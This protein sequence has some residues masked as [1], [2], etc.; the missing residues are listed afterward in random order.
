M[1]ETLLILFAWLVLGALV[2][3]AVACQWLGS[4]NAVVLDPAGSVVDVALLSVAYATVLSGQALAFGRKTKRVATTVFQFLLCVKAVCV[5]VLCSDDLWPTA[6]SSGI[7]PMYSAVTLAFLASFAWT[8]KD[9]DRDRDRDAERRPDDDDDDGCEYGYETL[10]GDEEGDDERGRDHGQDDEVRHATIR[11]LLGFAAPDAL[12]LTTGFV[13][14]SLAA[15]GMALVPYLSGQVIDYASIDPDRQMFAL[16]IWRLLGVALVTGV[17]T[18]LRGGLFTFATTKLTVR[19]RTRLFNSLLFQ[20]VGIYDMSKSGDITSRLAA[21]TTTVPDNVCLNMNIMMRSITQAAMVLVFMFRT[22]WR[23][24]V[25][26][27]TLVPCTIVVTKVYGRIYQKLAKQVQSRLA[28]ANDVAVESLTGISTV[29]THAAEGSVMASYCDR[30]QEYYHT[31]FKQA[32]MYSAYMVVSTFLSAGVITVGKWLSLA[33]SLA[34]SLSHPRSLT[35]VSR[36]R[37]A[38]LWFGGS[39]VFSGRMSP[40]DL[41]SFMLYQQSLTGSFQ[42]LGDVFSSL[43]GAIGAADKVV[44]L[45]ERRPAFIETGTSK[46]DRGLEGRIELRDVTFAYP[47]RMQTKVLDG[48]SLHV[49][50]GEVVALVGP[51]GGGKSS[52]VK[53]IERQYLPQRGQILIDGRDIGEY[54]KKWLRRRIGLVGQEPT[55]FARTIRRNII[56]GLEEADGLSE[57]EVPT[58]HQIEEAAKLANA[59]DFIMS[60]PK[61]YDTYCGERGTALSGGQ[62]QRLAIARALVRR[63]AMLLLDEATSALDSNSEAMVQEALEHAMAGRSVIVIAHRLSTIQNADRICVLQKGRIVEQGTHEELLATGGVYEG[64][65][66]RQLRR[67]DSSLSR[68]VSTLDT[69]DVDRMRQ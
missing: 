54:D 25:V 67:A 62:K 24:T 10:P 5:A 38:V 39:L 44:E 61:G 60:L 42:Q 1:R 51:S 19:I 52:I 6:G 7:V 56:Y 47:A 29:K 58:K 2:A 57:D 20:D 12:L 26:T 23:L 33:D 8:A 9:R 17:F 64:L 3:L 16:S 31:Q 59:H 32:I 30:L 41:V 40:G 37:Q 53:L 68:S 35:H 4:G 55:L 45:I 46:P 49:A 15:L 36:T 27:I 69:S 48:F 21:A 63:P 66:A 50:P 43:A 18:G 11:A 65:V 13:F 34:C 28:D 22:S 14:G